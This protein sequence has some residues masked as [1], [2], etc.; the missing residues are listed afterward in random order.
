[1]LSE[2]RAYLSARQPATLAAISRVLREVPGEVTE[3]LDL[4][5]GPGTGLLAAREIFPSI[6]RAVLVERDREMVALGKEMVQGF[7]PEWVIGD[8]S[9]VELPL[10]DLGLMAY[11]LNELE[12]PAPIL[13]R[14]FQACRILVLIEPGT[15]AG[16]ERILR[17]REQLIAL[18]GSV[19]APC[20][21]NRACP[22]KAPDWCHF[23]ARVSRTREHRRAK[24][25]DLG[26]EDE[27]FSYVIVEKGGSLR[28][29]SRILARPQLLKGHLKLKLCTEEGLKE[30]VVTKGAGPLYRR[31]RKSKWGD[32]FSKDVIEDREQESEE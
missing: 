31:A 26:F 27:K 12:D 32:L 11:V 30:E 2:K 10:S 25:A 6:R 15:P 17:A 23:A 20:P 24:G 4:G 9:R 28:G 22:M 1:T 18:G 3:L 8:L 13:E 14:A 5:A 21:H 19:L 7:N 29:I 16:F